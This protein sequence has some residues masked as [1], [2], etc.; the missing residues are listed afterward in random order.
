MVDK[1]GIYYLTVTYMCMLI[2]NR[3]VAAKNEEISGPIKKRMIIHNSYG[4]TVTLVEDI[5]T[6][7][8]Y[9]D[10]TI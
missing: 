10:S 7:V 9:N 4:T 8:L 1:V 5:H 2:R 6:S 3:E